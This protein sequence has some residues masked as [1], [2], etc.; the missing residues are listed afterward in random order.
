MCYLE[1]RNDD[2]SGHGE[3]ITTLKNVSATI[4]RG[5][6]WRHFR[7]QAPL[8]LFLLPFLADQLFWAGGGGTLGN[9]PAHPFCLHPFLI[10]GQAQVDSSLWKFKLNE[11][12]Y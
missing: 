1:T 6:L 5:G 11:E 4:R 9:F 3:N 8:Y 10:N 12:F 2:S 7:G